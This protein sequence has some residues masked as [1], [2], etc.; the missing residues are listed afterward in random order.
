MSATAR[1]GVRA[2]GRA[3]GFALGALDGGVVTLDGAREGA[4]A[5]VLVFLRHL[6]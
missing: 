4:R 1:P 6:G 2:G 3:P 5:V